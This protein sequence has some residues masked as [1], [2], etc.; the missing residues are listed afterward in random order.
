MKVIM[1]LISKER[2]CLV[3]HEILV[4]RMTFLLSYLNADIRS[5]V[6]LQILQC[7]HCETQ[8]VQHLASTEFLQTN[9]QS[10]LS[11]FSTQT[12]SHK[13]CSVIHMFEEELTRD[14]NIANATTVISL[15]LC[16]C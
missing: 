11:L 6:A 4:Q 9:P 15:Q 10:C 14:S 16:N 3:L 8:A 13:S 7:L 2:W 1:L 5:R 12:N